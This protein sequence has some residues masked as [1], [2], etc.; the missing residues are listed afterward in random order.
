MGWVFLIAAALAIASGFLVV[1]QRNPIYSAI[2]LVV[3]LGCVAV[4]YLLL[5]AQFLFAVQIIVYAGAIMVL[6]L[7][8]I[9]LLSPGKEE[10]RDDP[11]ARIRLPA[12][13]LGALMAIALISILGS[14]VIGGQGGLI[15]YADLGT[16][17]T[18]GQELYTRFLFP[19]EVTSVL[20]LVAIVG[21]LVLARRPA[22]RR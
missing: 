5:N 16:P 20:L 7:F 9:T 2:A 14:N 22:R 21:A 13:V 18:V 3:N 19:F 4:F 15:S 10:T 8:V 17:A 6:F 1:L 11:L 12:A